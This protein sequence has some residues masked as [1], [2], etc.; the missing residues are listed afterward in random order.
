MFEGLS[1]EGWKVEFGLDRL[2]GFGFEW[3]F[4]EVVVDIVIVWGLLVE[5]PLPKTV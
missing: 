4:G 1:L 5:V 3:R 2:L